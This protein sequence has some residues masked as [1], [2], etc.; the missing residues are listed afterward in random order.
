MPET[1]A[2]KDFKHRRSIGDVKLSVLCVTELEE[3]KEKKGGGGREERD[4]ERQTDR[5]MQQGQAGQL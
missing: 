3:E 2:H 1:H 5:E 4:R